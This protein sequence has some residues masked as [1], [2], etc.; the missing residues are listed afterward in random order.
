MILSSDA[1]DILRTRKRRRKS[2]SA[3]VFSKTLRRLSR[4][5]SV[6][7]KELRGLSLSMKH[8]HA[9]ILGRRLIIRSDCSAFVKAVENELKDQLPSEQRYLQRIKEY[10]PEIVHIPGTENYVADALSRPPQATSMYLRHYE[11]DSEYEDLVDPESGAEEEFFSETTDD[12]EEIISPEI[13]NKESIAL[14]QRNE[15]NLVEAARNLNK[16]IEFLQ[17]ENLAVIV[18]E[19][20][21]RIIL[22]KELWLAAFN[23][24]HQL[25]HLGIDK[26]TTIVAQD[27][28]WPTLKKDVEH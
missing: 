3:G 7:Y 8:F 13:I 21:N 28:W 16:K 14:L 20:N 10:E 11:S 15:P 24:A 1:S 19:N 27:Y 17:P 4:V 2:C 25:L 9:R 22:P 23:V 26:S 18:E 6:L 12:N 5:R